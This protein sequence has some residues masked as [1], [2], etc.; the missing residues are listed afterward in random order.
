[1]VA[2]SSIINS[3]SEINRISEIVGLLLLKYYKEHCLPVEEN[4]I[5]F[6]WKNCQ[7]RKRIKI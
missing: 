7:A 3:S 5:C 6:Y 4:K 1:M 2:P